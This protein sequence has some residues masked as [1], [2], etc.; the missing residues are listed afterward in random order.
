[1]HKGVTE[2]KKI[3]RAIH[4]SMMSSNCIGN[5]HLNCFG[6]MLWLFCL[7]DQK[8]TRRSCENML[9]V[10]KSPFLGLICILRLRA[11]C[12]KEHSLPLKESEY[13]HVLSLKIQNTKCC[14]RTSWPWT[15]G[16][17]QSSTML[18]PEQCLLPS[19]CLSCFSFKSD[20]TWT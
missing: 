10:I 4:L 8:Q 9:S 17:H 2:V 15:R 16:L 18:K 7:L 12:F 1:M 14:K 6:C 20:K 19:L 13:F 5:W 3:N 11:I